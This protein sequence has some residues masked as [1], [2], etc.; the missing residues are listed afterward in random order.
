M[1]TDQKTI[2]KA[3]YDSLKNLLGSSKVTLAFNPT[4]LYTEQIE[5]S[6]LQSVFQEI[7]VAMRLKT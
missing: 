4:K 1:V 3:F 5:L 6:H 7:E 2:A